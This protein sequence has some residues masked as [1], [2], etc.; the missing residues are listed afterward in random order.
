MNPQLNSM[1]TKNIWRKKISKEIQTGCRT[2][3][4]VYGKLCEV[5]N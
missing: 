2:Q 5:L 4:S 3:T 1:K